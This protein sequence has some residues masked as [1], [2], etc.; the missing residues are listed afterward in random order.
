MRHPTF[1]RALLVAAALLTSILPR[2]GQAQLP[3]APV[4]Q[5]AFSNPGL[6]VAGNYASGKET[7]LGAIA[8]AY[9]PGAGRYQ[10]SGGVGRLSVDD[11]DETATSWGGRFAVPLFSFADGR[12]GIA[13]FVGYGGASSDSVTL[14]QV[15]AGVGAGWRMGLGA[16]RALSVYATGTYLWARTKVGDETVSKGLVRF[17]VAGDVTLIRNLGLTLGYEMG[18]NAGETE[19]GPRG[20]IFGVGLSWA[21]R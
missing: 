13:P 1:R 4:L 21:F 19:P 7:S 10:F 11:A 3:G 14:T 12:G 9:A 6:T 20:G 16:S 15:P 5:N 18:A 17:A 2:L 8:V